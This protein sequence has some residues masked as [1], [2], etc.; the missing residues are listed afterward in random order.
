MPSQIARYLAFL[1][2]TPRIILLHQSL[3]ITGC[4]RHAVQQTSPISRMG[5]RPEPTN[6]LQNVP[7]MPW[8]GVGDPV[9]SSRGASGLGGQVSVTT[10]ISHVGMDRVCKHGGECF[11][12][13]TIYCARREYVTSS[14][15]G[16]RKR[17][18]QSPKRNRSDCATGPS[19]CTLQR[20]TGTFSARSH[21]AAGIGYRH[22][23]A[24][25]THAHKYQIPLVIHPFPPQ[26]RR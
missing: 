3:P 22:L 10:E 19:V 21:R 7:E 24:L 23:L 1:T 20:T 4:L 11:G 8:A 25:S 5:S 14:S 17:S 12:N 18:S 16:L 15:S 13:K 9:S 26:P 6:Q 2:C